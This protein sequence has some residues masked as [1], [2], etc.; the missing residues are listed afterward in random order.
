MRYQGVLR[1]QVFPAHSRSL[2]HAGIFIPSAR[3]LFVSERLMNVLLIE[4]ALATALPLLNA[5]SETAYP[6]RLV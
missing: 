1:T 3:D 2:S 4:K 5:P 6:E